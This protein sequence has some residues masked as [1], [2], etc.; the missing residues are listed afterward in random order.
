VKKPGLLF[1]L[2]ATLFA[3][4][5][6]GQ[7]TNA[8][9]LATLNLDEVVITG[10]YEPQSV[11]KSVFRV[12]TIPMEAI[13]AKGAVKLQDVL[14]TE[15]NIRFSQDLALGGS[16]ISMQGLEGQN[17]KVLIDGVPMVGRQGTSNEVNL[18]QINVNSIERI[19]IIEGPMS[20]VYGA[21]ALAG[22]INIITKKSADGKLDASVKIHEESV[23]KEY[24]WQK[25]IHNES[26]GVGYAR[27]R[28]N[29]RGDFSRNFF[30]G[31]T[32]DSTG[33]EKMW[34]PKI[35]YLASGLV[36]LSSDRG[37]IYYRLDYLNED[38]FNPGNYGDAG[39]P[40]GEALDQNY[41]TNRFMHQLQGEQ[42]F[43]DKF[44]MNG[45]V[46]YTDYSRKTQSTTVQES[47]G[48]VRLA[49]GPGRQ[50]LT[51]FDGLTIRSTLQYKASRTVTLQPGID[52]NF[53]SGEGG[54]LQAGKQSIGDYAVF[55]SGE[56]NPNSWLQVRPG[57][58]SIYNTV[59]KAPP[60][61]PSVNVKMKLTTRQDVRVSYGRGFRA[62]SLRELYFDFVDGSHDIQG[63]PDLKAETSHSINGSYNVDLVKRD[64]L[65]VTSVAGFFFNDVSNKI[66]YAISGRSTTYMNIDKFKTQGLTWN[67]TLRWNQWDLRA[68]FGYT[69][70][71]NQLDED[72]DDVVFT[73]SPEATAT[74]TY[75][76]IN[77][78]WTFS[79]FYKFTG[80]TPYY[81]PVAENGEQTYQLAII[82]SYS[83]ADASVQKRLVKGFDLGLGARN[84]FNVTNINSGAAA[85]TGVHTGGGSRPIGSGRSYFLSLT[86]T[87][88]Q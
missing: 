82:E 77:S 46:A 58:R 14:N 47:N 80:K 55:L 70:R 4:S 75:S 34:H 32:G 43:S 73:W 83:W 12:R 6:Y 13:Q 16:N 24:G 40:A 33:R 76:T 36:G 69:G 2:A 66:N 15:L 72:I 23:G 51:T 35:Q 1:C 20:V 42:R 68:G 84:L 7:D 21:D 31:Y 5:L 3:D 81:E 17:V 57:L 22:V 71:S 64:G 85:S 28:W 49:L 86:Y 78:G 61:V 62:P 59:Y 9:T 53:E 60:V 54:R 74:A 52:L 25:G 18:N 37:K 48:D 65:K 38:I 87:F 50:D 27:S 41:I 63:N 11:E 79:I 45:A 26:V 30:G 44:S 88:N 56:W 8:D 19:E 29:A 10:Q 67:N 39:S